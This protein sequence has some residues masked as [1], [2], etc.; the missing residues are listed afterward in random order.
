MTQELNKMLEKDA[1]RDFRPTTYGL[2]TY[3][4]LVVTPLYNV[5]KAVS[6]G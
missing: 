6:F 3:L 4:K 2:N 5:V 1:Y